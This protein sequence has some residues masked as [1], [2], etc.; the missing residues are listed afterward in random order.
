MGRGVLLHVA[1]LS[2]AADDV[3]GVFL[4]QRMLLADDQA[5]TLPN[6][7]IF[8]NSHIGNN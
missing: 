4:R 2:D 5:V 7:P 6:H 1:G 3:D 8:N